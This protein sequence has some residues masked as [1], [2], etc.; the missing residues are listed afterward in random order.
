[1]TD[2]SQLMF[3]CKIIL[4]GGVTTEEHIE[5]S[6]EGLVPPAIT[7]IA[8]KHSFY[9]WKNA[10][11]SYRDNF[12]N[13]CEAANSSVDFVSCVE[14]RTYSLEEAVSGAHKGFYLDYKEAENLTE[15]HNWT[16]DLTSAWQ[17]R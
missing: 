4:I 5:R 6:P 9:G 11:L 3:F 13:I 15:D 17:G 16:W 2:L 12:K 7:F 1:M 8:Y 14:D 10:S